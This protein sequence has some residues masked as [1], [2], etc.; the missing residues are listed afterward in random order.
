[1]TI[2]FALYLIHSETWKSYF[3][4]R[5]LK[6]LSAAPLLIY[7]THYTGDSGYV[8]DTEDSPLVTSTS[9]SSQRRANSELWHS[10]WRR[11]RHNLEMGL[12]VLSNF[13]SFCFQQ[14]IFQLFTWTL[15]FYLWNS[16]LN[17]NLVPSHASSLEAIWKL[18]RVAKRFTCFTSL[19]WDTIWKAC[20]YHAEAD[21]YLIWYNDNIVVSYNSDNF[22]VNSHDSFEIKKLRYSDWY[23]YMN[24]AYVSPITAAD[25]T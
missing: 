24:Q 6:A 15:K 25:L 20:D 11:H 5:D 1:M 21:L 9:T 7:P 2:K 3:P 23:F 19:R 14:F 16:F 13:F 10:A 18:E 8:S 17:A 22:V 4:K 12:L